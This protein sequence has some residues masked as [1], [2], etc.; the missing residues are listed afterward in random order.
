MLVVKSILAGLLAV[1]LPMVVVFGIC[2]GL[3]IHFFVPGKTQF[4]VINFCSP[5]LWIVWIAALAGGFC[6]EHLR[7]VNR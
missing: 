3:V 1:V 2:A 4:Y 7:L 5:F 6:W